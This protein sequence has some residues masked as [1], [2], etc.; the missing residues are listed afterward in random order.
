MRLHPLYFSCG[1]GT[2]AGGGAPSWG[3]A[4]AAAAASTAAAAAATAPTATVAAAAAAGGVEKKDQLSIEGTTVGTLLTHSISRL[5]LKY[6]V[7]Q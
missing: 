6:E 3:P 4:A 2:C 7:S 5:R 1:S